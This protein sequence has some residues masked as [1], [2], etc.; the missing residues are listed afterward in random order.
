M[1]IYFKIKLRKNN[2]MDSI[3]CTEGPASKCI[4]KLDW[5]PKTKSMQRDLLA[6][7]LFAFGKRRCYYINQRTF[8]SCHVIT[9]PTLSSGAKIT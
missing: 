6:C 2:L 5:K 4:I 8:N 3:M 9:V 1:T 7:L